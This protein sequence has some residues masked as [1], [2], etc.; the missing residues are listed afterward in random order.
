MVTECLYCVKPKEFG[1]TYC[2]DPVCTEHATVSNKNV[3]C[4]LKCMTFYNKAKNKLDP[5]G[6]FPEC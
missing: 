6:M 3:F 4:T 5:E 1:C 2:G